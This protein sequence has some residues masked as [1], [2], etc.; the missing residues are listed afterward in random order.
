MARARADDEGF[1]DLGISQSS[2][3][4]PQHLDLAVGEAAGIGW[5]M[6]LLLVRPG[7]CMSLV[8]DHWL[9]LCCEGLLRPNRASLG[10]GLAEGLF[11]ELGASG[12]D[13]A[14]IASKL[15]RRERHL[16][17][18]A[19]GLCR[20]QESCSPER[21]SI[22]YPVWEFS[23]EGRSPCLSRVMSHQQACQPL[24]A[25]GQQTLVAHISG[26]HQALFK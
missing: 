22:G 10:P 7:V 17:C 6:A 13:R 19:Q 2:C 21:T 14:F 24:E 9:F 16:D 26:Q 8:G 4:Q 11:T 5:R 23:V 15:N 25:G 12:S 3:N 18:F 20:S 1:R